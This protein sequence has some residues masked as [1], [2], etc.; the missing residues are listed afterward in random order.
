MNN[1]GE[2]FSFETIDSFDE[3]ISISIPMYRDIWVLINH[4]STY[5]IKDRSSVYDIG[6]ST[7][8]G[9]QYIADKT[10]HENVKYI[11]FDIADNLL[12][13]VNTP[14]V[15]KFK[16]DITNESVQFDNAS[17]VLSIF[18][19]QFIETKHRLNILKRIYS[20]LNIGGGCII[21]EKTI[22]ANGRLQDLFTFS[23]Y[24]FKQKSFTESEILGKQ[25]AL[26]KLMYNYT[27]EELEQLFRQAGFKNVQPFFQAFNFK[28]WVLIK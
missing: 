3:H 5:F 26:R 14:R 4:M 15:V 21:C 10:Q 1:K 8:Q 13:S 18:T 27:P 9:L 12:T 7:G 23:Y 16:E 22:A 24:D 20:G 6:C 28:G 19:L 2:L 11:G 25:K 17:L